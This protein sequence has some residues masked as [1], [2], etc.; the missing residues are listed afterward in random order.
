MDIKNFDS[1][2]IAP[3]FYYLGF[4]LYVISAVSG[5]AALAK[6]P[7]FLVLSGI[8]FVMAYNAFRTGNKL[9]NS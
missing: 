1:V 2:F 4:V 8:F 3:V 6:D 9:K 5:A 7:A